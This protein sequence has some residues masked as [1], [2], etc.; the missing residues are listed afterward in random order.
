[1]PLFFSSKTHLKGSW[2]DTE[3]GLLV[4]SQGSGHL[5]EHESPDA[6]EKRVSLSGHVHQTQ[7]RVAKWLIRE[8]R[9]AGVGRQ[10]LNRERVL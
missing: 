5:P 8:K 7:R 9:I 6:T 10:P 4:L 1:M 3:V 2:E